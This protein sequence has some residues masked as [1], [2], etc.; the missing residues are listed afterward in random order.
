MA[1][2]TVLG[3]SGTGKSY[4]AGYLLEQS[5][6][7]FDLTVHYDIENEERGLSDRQN[8]PLYET[9]PVS[10]KK[11]RQLNWQHCILN[12]PRLRVVPEGLTSDEQRVLYAEI[13]RIVMR[14]CKDLKPS[15]SALV[16]CDEAH[17]VL[18]QSDFPTECERLITG[19]RKHAVECLHIS[20]RPQLLHSTVISQ[21]DRRVYFSVSDSNDLDKIDKTSAFPA[22]ML[23]KL[24]ARTCIVE[25]KDTGEWKEV[26]TDGI[27]R[28]R[29]HYSG[30]DGIIDGFLPG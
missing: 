26:D 28:K 20:Q 16:S 25:N 29:P 24:P 27:G 6:P 8:N 1:R 4:Y 19:G 3:R 22:S 14:I 30:D 21:A 11:A 5:V 9:L 23:K 10:A 2:I 17:N 15:L 18:R 12:H 13:C 7:E